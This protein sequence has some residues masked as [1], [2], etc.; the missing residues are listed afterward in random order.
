MFEI[1]CAPQNEADAREKEL[2][3]EEQKLVEIKRKEDEL[4]KIKKQDQKSM[5]V[6]TEKKRMEAMYNFCDTTF[7]SMF[8]IFFKFFIHDDCR[9]DSSNY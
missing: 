3:E 9:Y 5:K 1:V 2:Q 6:E 8:N 4:A 7:E